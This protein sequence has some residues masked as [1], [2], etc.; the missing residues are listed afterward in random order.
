[1]KEKG[2]KDSRVQS[3][4]K[5]RH[6]HVNVPSGPDAEH[7]DWLLGSHCMGCCG[8][9]TPLESHSCWNVHWLSR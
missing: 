6:L 8:P 4:P 1:M 3:F 7:T 5:G 9:S 2:I